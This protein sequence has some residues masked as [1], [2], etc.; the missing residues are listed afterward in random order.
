MYF[1]STGVVMSE[2]ISV[3]FYATEMSVETLELCVYVL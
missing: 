2:Y 1:Y 3:L